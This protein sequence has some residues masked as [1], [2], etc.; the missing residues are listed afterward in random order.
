MK[1]K[2]DV[3]FN[4]LSNTYSLSSSE[5]IDQCMQLYQNQEMP[6]AHTAVVCVCEGRKKQND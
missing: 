3:G 4:L 5:F 1:H 2:P 6:A